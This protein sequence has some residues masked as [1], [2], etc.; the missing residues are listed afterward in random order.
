MGFFGQAIFC[1]HNA[2]LQVVQVNSKSA[3]GLQR[4]GGKVVD[5][6][7][8]VVENRILQSFGIL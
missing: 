2:T 4:E 8:Q 1:G 7:P 5:L 6:L 3:T